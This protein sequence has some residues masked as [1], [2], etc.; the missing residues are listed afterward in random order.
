MVLTLFISSFWVYTITSM[1]SQREG[2]KTHMH[3]VKISLNALWRVHWRGKVADKWVMVF[4]SLPLD[5]YRRAS[6]ASF[7]WSA[8]RQGH[9]LLWI[10]PGAQDTTC[11]QPH[12][13]SGL[14]GVGLPF[15]APSVNKSIS[16]QKSSLGVLCSFLG[17]WQG[18]CYLSFCFSRS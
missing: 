7:E 15:S 3:F 11:G 13:Y 9:G 4:V 10:A 5:L 17:K 2:K 12:C 1:G 16:I 8:L 14:G 6:H 18:L